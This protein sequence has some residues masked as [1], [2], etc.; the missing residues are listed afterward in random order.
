[1]GSQLAESHFS[2]VFF[3]MRVRRAG[4][5]NSAGPVDFDA[6]D[7]CPGSDEV[8]LRREHPARPLPESGPRGWLDRRL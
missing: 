8:R 7:Y 1:M 4:D 2:T 6:V 3:R 5:S